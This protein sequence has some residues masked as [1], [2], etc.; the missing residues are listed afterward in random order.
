MQDRSS[1]FQ[2]P[3]HD[4]RR[5]QMHP[6]IEQIPLVCPQ[7][8]TSDGPALPLPDEVLGGAAYSLDRCV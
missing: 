6:P 5:S 3:L 2:L 8:R 4:A 7:S 1:D